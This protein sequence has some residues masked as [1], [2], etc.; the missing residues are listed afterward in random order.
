MSVAEILGPVAVNG[1]S[2]LDWV[3]VVVLISE[4]ERCLLLFN[5]IG[6]RT[7]E[8]WANSLA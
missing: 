2:A 5:Q 8:Q 1:E 3:V 7:S 6:K 4:S